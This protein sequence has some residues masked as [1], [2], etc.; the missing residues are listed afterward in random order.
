MQQCTA[1]PIREKKVVLVNLVHDRLTDA[2]TVP[3][4]WVIQAIQ[5]ISCVPAELM[6][7]S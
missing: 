2:H 1:V 4:N 3:L 7:L 6:V 5:M